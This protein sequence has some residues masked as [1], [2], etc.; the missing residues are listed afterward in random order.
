MGLTVFIKCFLVPCDTRPAEVEIGQVW[1]PLEDLNIS[2]D[3]P[4]VVAVEVKLGQVSKP[5]E[6]SNVPCDARVH[7]DE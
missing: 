2:K 3:T 7:D 1:K 4:A 5:L 6:D